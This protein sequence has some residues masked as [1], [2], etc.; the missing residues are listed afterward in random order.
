MIYKNHTLADRLNYID[1][2]KVLGLTGIIVAHVGSPSWV[3]MLRSFDVPLMVIL[4]AILGEKS[5]RKYEDISITSAKQYFSSRVKRLV[6][7]TWIFLTLYFL[8]F[9]VF[10]G[11]FHKMGYYIASYCLT[12]Y[13]IG[14]VWIILIYL[15]SAMLIPLFSKWQ[16]SKRG[17]ILIAALYL[18][19]ETAYFFGIGIRNKLLD[20]TVFYIIP[21]GLLTY[22]GCN[23]H[24]LTQK[25]RFGIVIA[26]LIIF[27]TFGAY[28]WIT[29]GSPQL[30][31]IAKY[32]PRFYYL[33][34]G[35]MWSISL[36]MLCE[37]F[38]LKIYTNPLVKY[39]STH[40]MWIYL[41]HIFALS[42]YRALKLPEKW[43]L[44]LF[45]VYSLA[46]LAVF[47]TNK[48]LDTIEKKHTIG[49]L[50]YFRG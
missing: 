5:Y 39:I 47:V 43:F 15:Y 17:L 16:L 48:V 31:Q 40:S 34:Y 27:V 9:D 35:L 21:Y 38:S 19:Y 14:Y 44:K 6:I 33:S 8:L 24:K 2:L 26:S 7:P 50:Q 37:K 30:V 23:Y 45:V 20:T 29:S 32:P 13:G 49:F 28:Y 10:S 11:H 22:I 3:M 46:L 42:A 1:F 18:S 36:L 41:W 4:S 12:R 25:M